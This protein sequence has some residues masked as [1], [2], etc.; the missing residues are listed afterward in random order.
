VTRPRY[1]GVLLLVCCVGL[2]PAAAQADVSAGDLQI[3]GRALGFLDKPM[4]GEVSVGIVYAAD[5]A[6]SAHEAEDL[7]RMLAGGVRVGN[8]LLKPVPV[9]LE[10]L[11]QARVD[12]LFLT[13]GLGAQATPVGIVSSTRK[14]PCITA[15]L[16]QV[17]SGRCAVGVSAQPTVQILVNRAAALASGTAFSTL[18]RM[19]INEI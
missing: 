8:V 4:S 7:Q 13:G 2:Q 15:D 3:M 11:A 14:L 17:Q 12:V 19:M 6:Q 16:S 10:H 1:G 5:N 9:A 18:F